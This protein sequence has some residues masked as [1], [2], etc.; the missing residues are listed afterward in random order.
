MSLLGSMGLHDVINNSFLNLGHNYVN[1][2]SV[3]TRIGDTILVQQ[4]ANGI[5]DIDAKENLQWK[6]VKIPKEA[7]I[8]TSGQF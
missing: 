7:I 4:Q 2:A 3:D 8:I 5:V 1:N 6:Q